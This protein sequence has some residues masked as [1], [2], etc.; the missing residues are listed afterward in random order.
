MSPCMTAHLLIPTL[1]RP[2]SYLHSSRF[3]RLHLSIAETVIAGIFTPLGRNLP[4]TLLLENFAFALNCLFAGQQYRNP[5]V[6]IVD[7][8]E[9]PLHSVAR[10]HKPFVLRY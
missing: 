8:F 10:W 1:P 5:V 3:I 6:N 4:I 9:K 2:F 7:R